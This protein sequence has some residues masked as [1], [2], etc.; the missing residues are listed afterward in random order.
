MNYQQ[1][2][3]QSWLDE[4]Y[5]PNQKLAVANKIGGDNMCL[6][7]KNVEFMKTLEYFNI[8]QSYAVSAFRSSKK[9]FNTTNHLINIEKFIES[10]WE[11]K[12]ARNML[13]IIKDFHVD[14]I[15]EILIATSPHIKSELKNY[16]QQLYSS[17]MKNIWDISVISIW[18]MWWA[19]IKAKVL[20]LLWLDAHYLDTLDIWDLRPHEIGS[21]VHD[22]LQAQLSHIYKGSSTAIPI[23][24][25]YLW[26]IQGWI[27]SVLWRWYTDYTWER[28]AVA[29]KGIQ[30]FDQVI[31]YI[32]KLF[33]FKST[34]PYMLHHPKSAQSINYLSYDLTE[35]VIGK[36][37]AQAW[38]INMHVLS[39]DI[40]NKSIKILVWNPTDT[41]DKAII[42]KYG[43]R[44]STGVDLVLTRWMNQTSDYWKYNFKVVGWWVETQARNI[45]Y[46]I[47]E[48]MKNID[49]IF[50]EACK[51]LND[52]NITNIAWELSFD[53]SDP[54][55]LVFKDQGT[56]RSALVVLHEY[57]IERPLKSTVLPM[58]QI[59]E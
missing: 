26:E 4:F 43:N 46:L 55:S 37:W 7:I 17:D 30:Q 39:D 22:F 53:A 33:W 1:I 5:S 21:R 48:N 36:R 8:A 11:Y 42:D 49:I 12:Q 54:I 15:D 2:L 35:R 10:T 32:Q 44:Y 34:D 47:W 9:N 58:K 52:N 57:F 14:I 31:L 25:W 50:G 16:I 59:N 20:Q 19:K 41:S 29:L 45:V 23:I 28:S 6:L 24:P 27:I 56:A 38:L 13:T 40:R 18:E 51:V 3:I